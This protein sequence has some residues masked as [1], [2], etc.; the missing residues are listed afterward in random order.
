[1]DVHKDDL[2]IQSAACNRI[3]LSLYKYIAVLRS[4]MLDNLT[5]L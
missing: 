3:R 2:K 4:S 5:E 1:M